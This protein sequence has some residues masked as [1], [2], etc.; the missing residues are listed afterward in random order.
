MVVV[1]TSTYNQFFVV[2]GDIQGLSFDC[3][4]YHIKRQAEDKAGF[5]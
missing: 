3:I 2:F 1:R 5:L 4:S